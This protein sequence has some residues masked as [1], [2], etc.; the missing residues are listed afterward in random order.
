MEVSEDLLESIE[1]SLHAM[2]RALLRDVADVLNIPSKVLIQRIYGPGGIGAEKVKLVLSTTQQQQQQTTHCKVLVHHYSGAFYCGIP[3]KDG[4]QFCE[5]HYKT[6][7]PIDRTHGL[8]LTSI[9]GYPDLFA[10][11]QGYVI[12]KEGVAVGVL[13]DTILY[14]F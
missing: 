2:G 1:I 8:K 4:A 11:P 7:V 5:K 3:V 6:P 14:K 13:K 12:T 9:Q 10:T